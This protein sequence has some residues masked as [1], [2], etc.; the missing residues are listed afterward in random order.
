MNT[1]LSK[2]AT[3]YGRE[4]IRALEA[5]G[6]DDLVQLIE[7]D[8]DHRRTT[9]EPT[10]GELGA[11]ELDPRGDADELEAA[12]ALCRSVG[13]WAV[14]YPVA[15]RLARPADLDVDGLVVV[16]DA[17]PKA[18]IACL[19][20]RW[21]A[22]SIDGRRSLVDA[23]PPS[24]P[25]RMSAF[26][27]QLDLRPIDGDGAKDLALAL[28]LPCWTLLGMLDRAMDLTRSH[29]LLR[30]QFG[31]PLATLQG[32][33]FQLTEAEVERTG[34]DALAKYT[35]WSIQAGNDEAVDDALAFRLAAVEAAQIVFRVAHQLH[36]ASGFCDETTVSWISRYSIPLRRIP[37]GPSGTVDALTKRIDRRGLT[38]LFSETPENALAPEKAML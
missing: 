18:P 19:D 30:E 25:P 15:E 38:G 23:R 31:A 33:Q 8:P 20:L 21:A 22:V 3:E 28:T 13:Y 2:E 10:L 16:D 17:D 11:W 14:P 35:L 4:A 5:A 36:G 24:T 7:S 29:V 34:L 32:V 9:V 26:T 6:G 1:E 27:S 37:W 12:A